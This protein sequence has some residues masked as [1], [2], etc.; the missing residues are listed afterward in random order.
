MLIGLN[1]VLVAWVLL[2]LVRYRAVHRLGVGGAVGVVG[3]AVM[4]AAAGVEALS[5]RWHDQFAK[6]YDRRG[7]GGLF[8]YLESHTPRATPI[9]V[10]DLSVYPYFGSARQFRVIQPTV[11]G[12]SAEWWRGY[13][14]A[15]AVRLVVV[16]SKVGE[17]W[18]GCSFASDW[19]AADPDLFTR[20]TGSAWPLSVYR[21]NL[22]RARLFCNRPGARATSHDERVATGAP[23]RHRSRDGPDPAVRVGRLLWL[24]RRRDQGFGTD[25]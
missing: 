15:R 8:H 11:M 10:L 22:D 23:A 7:G 3:V 9:C 12:G 4:L 2:L 5:Q 14:S 25:I 19:C 16:P 24:T 18:L 1:V 17:H 21:V 6:V 20:L 13:L